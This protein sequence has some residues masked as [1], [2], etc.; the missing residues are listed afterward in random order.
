MLGI[1]SKKVCTIAIETIKTART[2]G[3]V[4]FN[5]TGEALSTNADT[6]FIWIPGDMPVNVP[7]IIPKKIAMIISKYMPVNN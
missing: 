5:K 7:E 6:R 3:D 2:I 4:Y 1:V